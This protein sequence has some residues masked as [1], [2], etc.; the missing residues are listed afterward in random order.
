MLH[1]S[2]RFGS[3]SDDD[4]T[5]SWRMIE[6][7]KPIYVYSKKNNSKR[8]THT[9]QTYQ[10]PQYSKGR[11]NKNFKKILCKNIIGP[12]KSHTCTYGNKCEYAHKLEEQTVDNRR[13][14]AYDL[15]L[16]NEDLS[17]I[18]LSENHSLYRSLLE[19]TTLC[20]KC[21]KNECTGGYNCK[22]GACMRKYHICQKDLNFGN[23]ST[24]CDKIHLSKRGL[25][26]FF[27]GATKQSNDQNI[28]G[29]L[30]SSDF[31]RTFE[32]QEN[33]NDELDNFSDI[34]DNSSEHD[35]LDECNQSIFN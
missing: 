20:L 31:F 8:D 34:S 4:S 11:N 9:Y 17:N 23:C 30:L 6:D 12:N 1:N 18:N 13:K 33:K 32:F 15:L 25:K 27:S 21:D 24:S 29:T 7:D 10:S 22:Y 35:Q 26:S 2:S 16:N 19:L 3:D 14:R 28:Q 5:Q